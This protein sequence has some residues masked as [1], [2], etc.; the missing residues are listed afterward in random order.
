M[1]AFLDRMNQ[2]KY[3]DYR[4]G[5]VSDPRLTPRVG[6]VLEVTEEERGAV[7]RLIDFFTSA[8]FPFQ[9]AELDEMILGGVA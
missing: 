9:R 3:G 2:A 4:T 6:P 1:S 5:G 8:A 7:K